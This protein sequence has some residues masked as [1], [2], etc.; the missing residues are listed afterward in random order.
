MPTLKQ[1]STATGSATGATPVTYLDFSQLAALANQ[2]V[3]EINEDALAT[4]LKSQD[5]YLVIGCDE[6]GRGCIFGPVVGAAVALGA[7]DYNLVAQVQAQPA[8]K[9]LALATELAHQAQVAREVQLQ[10]MLQNLID[11]VK[12]I[13]EPLEQAATTAPQ[14]SSTPIVPTSAQGL[15]AST[16]TSEEPTPAVNAQAFADLQLH[17]S[18]Q[19]ANPETEFYQQLTLPLIGHAL[20]V[21]IDYNTSKDLL[22]YLSAMQDSKSISEAKRTRLMQE[23]MQMSGLV[24]QVK[25]ISAAEVD[26]T[27]IL[28]A[29]LKAMTQCV[30]S[31]I[32]ELAIRAKNANLDFVKLLERVVIMVDGNQPL[33]I[34]A[35]H[36][37]SIAKFFYE[38]N[39]LDPAQAPELKQICVVTGDR[40]VKEISVASIL[41]KVLRDQ[42]VDSMAHQRNTQLFPAETDLASLSDA[43]LKEFA[44]YAMYDLSSNKGYPTKK[45]L[46]AL[47]RYGAS[48]QH[49]KSYGPV[50]AVLANQS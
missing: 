23:F 21:G 31:V 44:P 13:Y 50:A 20:G 15:E 32:Y 19:T 17:A 36:I 38:N 10:T 28:Q 25:A 6:V 47:K 1:S 9:R 29:S 35:Q 24:C 5:Q 33:P 2:P 4:F 39:D 40:R 8:A 3:G 26:A 43:Q 7:I 37:T 16:S 11:K 42:L 48:D 27:N 41:A 34:T 14:A 46:D 30:L 22:N 12:A 18:Q 49:R 45:H